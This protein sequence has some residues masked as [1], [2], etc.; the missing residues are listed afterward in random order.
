[1]TCMWIPKHAQAF[2]WNKILS[3]H[4]LVETGFIDTVY[5]ATSFCSDFHSNTNTTAFRDSESNI[6][7]LHYFGVGFPTDNTQCCSMMLKWGEKTKQNKKKSNSLLAEWHLEQDGGCQSGLWLAHFMLLDMCK[8]TLWN[9]PC[10]P[11]S[12]FGPVAKEVLERRA[13]VSKTRNQQS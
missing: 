7:S 13:Q 11:G 1:M 4:F 2:F 8:S 6:C 5:Y 9:L 12:L 10:L 3:W